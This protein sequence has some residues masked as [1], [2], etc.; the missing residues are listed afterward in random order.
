MADDDR[1]RSFSEL[2][3]LRRERGGSGAPPRSGKARAQEEKRSQAALKAADA[4]F[5]DEKGGQAGKVLADAVREAHGTPE[6]ASACR[7]YLEEVGPPSNV[8]LASI[9]LDAG[10]KEIGVAVLDELL[11]VKEAGRLELTGGLLR[12]IRLLAEDFDDDLASRAEELLE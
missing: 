3:R 8:E 11:R 1:K 5:T 2:D 10:E 6:L 9:C 7:A 12:Q 4:L